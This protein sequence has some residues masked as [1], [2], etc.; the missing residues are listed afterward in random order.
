M[1]LFKCFIARIQ[2]KDGSDNWNFILWLNEKVKLKKRLFDDI[3]INKF[4]LIK[5]NKVI[6]KFYVYEYTYA[7]NK[8]SIVKYIQTAINKTI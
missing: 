3:E 2:C 1:E 8:T 7:Y 4:C 5:F 6:H